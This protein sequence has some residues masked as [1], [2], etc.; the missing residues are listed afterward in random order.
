MC[1]LGIGDVIPGLRGEVGFTLSAW[2]YR[3]ALQN[4]NVAEG[5][6]VAEDSGMEKRGE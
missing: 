1:S 6:H 4:C 5:S 3:C 2:R